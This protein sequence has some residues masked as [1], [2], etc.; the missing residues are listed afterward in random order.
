MKLTGLEI[1]KHIEWGSIVIDP[2]IPGHMGPNSYD[3]RLDKRLLVYVTEPIL[4]RGK[5][6]NTDRSWYLA[7]NHEVYYTVDALSKLLCADQALA[8][9]HHKYKAGF[10]DH[11]PL[12]T[13]DWYGVLDMAQDT[14]TYELIIPEKGLVLLPGRL[15][16]GSTMEYTETHQH[17]PCIEGRSSV[18]R[19]G[20]NVHSTAG[21]GDVGFQGTWTLEIS[22]VEPVRIYPGIRCCQIYYDLVEGQ[23]AKKYS[24][25]KYQGQR[26]PRSSAMWKEFVKDGGVASTTAKTSACEP[27]GHPAGDQ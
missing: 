4:G 24:S 9:G 23:I 22:V 17:V 13:E 11:V 12:E 27:G 20:I 7:R 1:Q 15:Y 25:D 19:L 21:F 26:G 5:I 10:G 16:I 6:D 14:P 18:G 3:L 2:F 8:A